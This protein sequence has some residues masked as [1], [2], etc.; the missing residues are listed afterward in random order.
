MGATN[1]YP[2][3]ATLDETQNAFYLLALYR[4]MSNFPSSSGK[5][6]NRPTCVVHLRSSW[7]IMRLGKAL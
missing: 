5:S 3:C 2:V 7:K 6:R 4:A 1:N